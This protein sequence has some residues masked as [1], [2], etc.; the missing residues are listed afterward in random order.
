MIKIVDSRIRRHLAAIRQPLRGTVG[1]LNTAPGVGLMQ[2]LGASGEI[3]QGVEFFQQFGFSSSPVRGTQVI[4]L[5]LGGKTSQSVVIACENGG[6]RVKNLAPGESVMYGPDG[7]QVY[8]SSSGIV[9]NS[10]RDVTVNAPDLVIHGISFMGHKH[11][12]VKAGSDLSGV[13]VA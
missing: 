8:M 5:P 10:T 2:V 11:R 6:L 7:D 12:D 4:V 13:P 9:V 1:T 3:L